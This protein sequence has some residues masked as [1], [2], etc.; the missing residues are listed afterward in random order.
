[1]GTPFGKGVAIAVM[2]AIRSVAVI[3]GQRWTTLVPQRVG[4]WLPAAQFSGD[5]NPA[6]FIGRNVRRL[7]AVPP[8]HHSHGGTG[9]TLTLDAEAADATRRL[10]YPTARPPWSSIRSRNSA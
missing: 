2:P 1:M 4:R 3:A 9:S 7:I 8:A 10:T 6:G 5:V